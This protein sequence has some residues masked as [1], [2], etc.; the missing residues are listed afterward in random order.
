VGSSLGLGM[1]AVCLVVVR[2]EPL[3]EPLQARRQAGV[4]CWSSVAAQPSLRV[5]G[6]P[7]DAPLLIFL[8]G[9]G[10]ACQLCLDVDGL[11]A[12]GGELG[13]VSL[14]LG[15]LAR[16]DRLSVAPLVGAAIKGC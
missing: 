5:C 3:K 12:L 14:K 11:A 1:L 7:R 2:P 15:A 10:R 6:T 13:I 16:Q 4:A 8:G 9:L